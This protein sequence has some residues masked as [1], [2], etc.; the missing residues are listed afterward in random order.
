MGY[1]FSFDQVKGHI[2]TYLENLEDKLLDKEDRMELYRLFVN[3]FQVCLFY[4]AFFSVLTVPVKP[5][6]ELQVQNEILKEQ[7]WVFK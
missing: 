1:F 5:K 4:H 2:Q 7:G 6:L 3:C